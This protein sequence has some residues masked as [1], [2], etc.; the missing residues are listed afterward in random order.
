M[1][2]RCNLNRQVLALSVCLLASTERFALGNVVGPDMQN[3]NATPDGLDFVTV[4]SSE[5]LRAGYWNLGLFVNQAKGTLPRFPDDGSNRVVGQYDDTLTGL[6]INMAYGLTN[7]ITLGL[8]LPQI[9]GQTVRSDEDGVR[10]EFL[11]NGATEIR[12]LLK[13][14][15]RGNARGGAALVVSSG[16]N[17]VEDNPYTGLG[18]P[19]IFNIELAM[20]GSFGL[21]AAGIN[22]GYRHRTPGS[23]LTG[24]PVEPLGSQWIASSAMS[25][26][27][28]S[29]K[30]RLI[31]EV[32]GS[33]PAARHTNRSDR[34][35]SSAEALVGI[36]HMATDALALHA[37]IGRELTHGIASPDLRAYAGLNY[38]FG[39]G[40]EKQQAQGVKRRPRGQRPKESNEPVVRD[41]V[42]EDSDDI[43]VNDDIPENVVPPTGEETFIVNN[44]MFA[45][46]RDNLV[47]PGGRD[48]LRKLAVYLMKAPQ[49]KHLS[50]EGHTDFLGSV[51]YNQELSLR[52]ATQIKRYLVEVLRLD[53][54]KIDVTGFGESRPIADNGNFQGRQLNRRVEFKINR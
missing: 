37:G 34:M 33:Q 5:T 50:I 54:A 14:R 9:L 8:S 43:L 15:L 51:A 30:S 44:V 22:L 35:L 40:V 28:P 41:F 3:F 12:P 29:I 7:R 49:F 16:I 1:L 20:D 2:I 4:Q 27:V 26:L 45:F 47:V 11:Q 46:D 53:G 24:A 21:W 25:V 17:M 18:S 23:P 36:K 19:P 6:D 31:L 39:P 52:R 32:F 13:Y 10:G 42:P 48:I 38:A